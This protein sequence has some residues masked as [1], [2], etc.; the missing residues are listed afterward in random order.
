[1]QG[2]AE[3]SMDR[4]PYSE[5]RAFR[6]TNPKNLLRD[7]ARHNETCSS[8]EVA[9]HRGRL[10][11]S[12]LDCE[13]SETRLHA[14]PTDRRLSG[15]FLGWSKNHTVTVLLVDHVGNPSIR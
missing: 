14:L 5:T 9:D 1:M 13:A 11:P 3:Q 4:I 2:W 15:G 10:H 8:F 6:S 12:Q 7:G